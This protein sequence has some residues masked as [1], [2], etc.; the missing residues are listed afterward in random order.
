MKHSARLL[1]AAWRSART[2]GLAGL[3]LL[4]GGTAWANVSIAVNNPSFE[5]FNPLNATGSPDLHGSWNNGPI[6]DW[7]ISGSGGSFQPTY[8]TFNAFPDGPISAWSNGGTI[9]QTVTPTAIA[10]DTYTLFVDIGTRLD[11][12]G[13]GYADL[14]I[15]GI[16][17]LATALGTAVAGQWTTWE[18]TYTATS[19]DAGGLIRIDLN[20]PGIQGNYDN[21]V[22]STPEPG[23]YGALALGMS[24]L[25]VVIQRRRR[26]LSLVNWF[27]QSCVAAICLSYYGG[28]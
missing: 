12:P 4:G 20:S 27:R 23:F 26:A 19:A 9:Y 2:F 1:R 18:A 10:G 6:P 13:V 17:H 24:G 14:M 11:A 25:L 28:G 5:T 7:T 21:V 16:P 8:L 22:L 3:L 15:N